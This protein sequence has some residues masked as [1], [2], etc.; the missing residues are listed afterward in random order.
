M[1]RQ[2][3][4]L[5]ELAI[6]LVIIGLL[7]G[8]VLKGQDLLRSAKEKNFYRHFVWGWK[9]V[10]LMYYDKTGNLLG[11][12]KDNGGTADQPDGY[13]DNVK[14]YNNNDIVNL[15]KA[16]GITPPSTNVGDP[17]EFAIKGKYIRSVVRAYLY[18]LYDKNEKAHYNVIYLVGV[19][20]DVAIA[21]D[22]I[23]DGKADGASG[24]FRRY[25]GRNEFADWPDAT[26]TKTVNAA[27]VVEL[28]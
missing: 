17:G 11:D 4:T 9:K 5:V 20:T 28:P 7:L 15:L 8:A 19:P 3:F 27:F 22:K 25:A 26:D 23:V 12:G 13:F 6:V 21:I 18:H 10:V 24:A 1:K 16:K 14:L 2:G